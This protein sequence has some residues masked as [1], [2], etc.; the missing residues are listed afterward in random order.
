MN[1]AFDFSTIPE[2][3]D[4]S[5]SRLPG[6]AILDAGTP[7]TNMFIVMSGTVLIKVGDTALETVSRGGV[8]GEMAMLDDSPR[9][10]SVVAGDT[11]EIVSIDRERCFTLFSQNPVFATALMRLIAQ[12]LR[13][14]NFF[15]DH[16]PMTRLP[17]RAHLEEHLHRTLTKARRNNT[18]IAVMA[19]DLDGFRSINDL[20]GNAMGDQLMNDAATRLRKLVRTE[21]YVARVGGDEFSIVV[22]NL[23]DV[24]NAVTLAQ[25]LIQEMAKPFALSGYQA[26]LS[27]SIGIS[28]YPRD[29]D[30][31][32]TLLKTA[33]AAAS[34]A[35]EQG[36]HVYQFFSPELNDHALE[37]LTITNRLRFALEHEQF[38]LHYQPR[39]DLTTGKVSGVEA[40]IRWND[41]QKGMISPGVF[42]PLAEKRGMIGAI[43]EWVLKEACRQIKEWQ[44]AG[45]PPLL[46]AVNISIEQLR[47]ASLPASIGG[48]LR[49]ANLGAQCLELE[50]TESTAMS[51]AENAVIALKV[52]SDMGL[53][54]AIDDFGTGY[55]SLSHLKRFPVTYLKIDQSFVRGIPSDP[56]DIAIV[57]TIIGMAKNLG[58]RLI[59]EGVETREQLEFL[60]NA[61][62][63]EA[64]GYLFSKP[65]PPNE[66]VRFLKNYKQV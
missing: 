32:K 29:G 12:R 54:L 64:Q 26:E 14:M 23:S 41:P 19:I 5:E 48:I 53:A 13:A 38:I 1:E 37:M 62:C 16:D 57:N 39:F 33:N 30:D 22:D 45:L 24:H 8:V 56:N 27:P 46:V 9:S 61:G 44:R 66:L 55:S 15:A 20:L 65:L 36:G 40:L 42:I 4:I 11:C 60:K 21:D 10:A 25:K 6:E 58:M 31:A 52:L 63:D 35:K 2:S 50:V 49:A 59:A 18:V 7:G 17:N 34:R 3:V 28:Y 51:D 47:K 43:G